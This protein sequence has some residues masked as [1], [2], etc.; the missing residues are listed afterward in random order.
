MAGR[1]VIFV[2]FFSAR[3]DFPSPPLSVP[4]S[5]R[6]VCNISLPVLPN[7]LGSVRLNVG[8][9]VVRTDGP[10]VYGHVITKFSGMG[11]F[12]QQWCSAGALRLSELRN[13][14]LMMECLTSFLPG[15]E[16]RLALS[17]V[18]CFVKA[19]IRYLIFRK[20]Q[21]LNRDS[22]EEAKE[23]VWGGGNLRQ[24]VRGLDPQK[25]KIVHTSSN[26]KCS[27]VVIICDFLPGFLQS[28]L[29]DSQ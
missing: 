29:K 15:T 12:T 24:R 13:N 3:L 14:A 1:K 26:I 20:L 21:G 27:T 8:C 11:R 9:P 19:Y 4:G 17:N 6:M 18:K 7:Q 28:V 5:P 22:R 16:C 23:K 2:S 25:Q 10:A